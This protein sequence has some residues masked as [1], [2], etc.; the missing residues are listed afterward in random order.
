MRSLPVKLPRGTTLSAHLGNLEWFSVD[1]L[2]KNVL[3]VAEQLVKDYQI[4][5]IFIKSNKSPV[6]P[7]Y[8]NQNVLDDMAKSTEEKTKDAS[9]HKV[10]IDG[11]E[12]ELSAFDAALM[13]IANP[14]ELDKVFAGSINKA[15]KRAAEQQETEKATPS[16]KAKA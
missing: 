13:Q 5:A 2:T 10:T 4:R 16:K 3:M 11:T 14:D 7:L 12:L 6:L 1:E 15:K 8:Y 9:L